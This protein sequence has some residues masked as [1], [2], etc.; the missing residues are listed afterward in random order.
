M[1]AATTSRPD[2]VA[3]SIAAA[4]ATYPKTTIGSAAS[5]PANVSVVARSLTSGPGMSPTSQHGTGCR[6]PGDK[7]ARFRA[8]CRPDGL[9]DRCASERYARVAA[10]P[11]AVTSAARPSMGPTGVSNSRCIAG[12]TF[13][14]HLSRWT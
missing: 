13:G 14:S 3:S 2:L 1:L 5:A 7:V 8:N 10:T 12:L 11:T 4:C 6:P 9:G